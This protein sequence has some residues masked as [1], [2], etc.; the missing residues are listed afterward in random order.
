MDP[1]T[2]ALRELQGKYK[3]KEEALEQLKSAFLLLLGEAMALKNDKGEN[4]LQQYRTDWMD[5]AG[6]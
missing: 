5:K 1:Q 2:E 4:N 6:L 3:T